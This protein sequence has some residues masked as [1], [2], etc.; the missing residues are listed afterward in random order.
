PPAALKDRILQAIDAP[1]AQSA[2]TASLEANGK[3]TVRFAAPRN[4][5]RLLLPLAAAVLVLVL[6]ALGTGL[7]VALAREQALR[8]ELANL[9]GQ[10]ELVLEVVDSSK[11]S[12]VILRSPAGSGSQSYGKLY[13][14]PDLPN[15]VAMAARL[16]QPPPGQAY[17]LWVSQRGQVQ[18]AGV[19]K[20]NDQGFGMLVFTADQPGPSYDLIQLTLQPLGAKT[21]SLP[22]VLTGKPTS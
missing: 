13:T 15:V 5:R 8:A 14:R 16:P 9:T 12:K 19:L 10:Q 7:S 4:R 11:M 18:L 1:V 6:L 21:P 17:H 3:A 20:I 2:P 22:A